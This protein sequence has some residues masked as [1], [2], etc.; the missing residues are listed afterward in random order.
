RRHAALLAA[1]VALLLPASGL[2]DGAW[3]LGTGQGLALGIVLCALVLWVSEAVPLFVTGVGV[4]LAGAAWLA[5]VLAVAP[6]TFVA[7]FASDVILLFLG[8]FVLSGVLER[9]GVAE[10]LARAVLARVG[11]GSDRVVLGVL[12]TTA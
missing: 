8:G 5:P 4:G 11:T 9:H 2:L 3:R 10:R 6:E 12:L 7:P 1:T